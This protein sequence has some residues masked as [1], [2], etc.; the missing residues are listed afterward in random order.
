MLGYHPQIVGNH[1]PPDP[2]LH[3]FIAVIPTAREP[4]PPFESTDASF[5][6]RSPVPSASEPPLPLVRLSRCRFASWSR[7][8]HPPHAA[9]RRCLFILGCRQFAIASDQIGRSAK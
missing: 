3:P 6:P 4:M 7:Q 8:H 9:L 5:D 1:T 2:T